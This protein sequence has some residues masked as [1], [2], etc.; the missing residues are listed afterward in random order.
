MARYT[1]RLLKSYF[2]DPSG[3]ETDD[4]VKYFAQPHINDDEVDLV[5][6]VIRSKGFV[7]GKY[8][9][10]LEAE[11]AE[12]VG[13]K[14]AIVTSNGTAALHLAI[15][16]LGITPGSE[17]ITPAF[18]FIASANAI[19]FG[20]SVPVFADIDPRTYNIDPD[21][22]RSLIT[23][24]T[25]AILPVHIFG[26][27]ADMIALSELAEDHSLYI[28]EDACQGHG[29]YIDNKHVGS[30]GNVGCFSFYATKNLTSGEGG[31]IVTDDDELAA[32]IRSLKNHGRDEKGGYNH[33][34]I[35]Y[36][37]RLADPLA[38]L[39]LV[40]LR[41]LPSMLEKR[42]RN[43]RAI[44]RV[45]DEIDMVRNQEIPNSFTHS[46]YI[47]AP[48]IINGELSAPN[49][50]SKL[51]DE[52]IGSRQIYTLP[53]HRQQTYLEGI[54]QWRWSQYVSYPDYAK[55]QLPHTDQ[56]ARSHFEIPIHPGVTESEIQTMG[57]LLLDLFK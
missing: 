42:H 38:A 24:K 28:I 39:G 8:A 14:H 19:S 50:V 36:N 1:A 31:M 6:Q 41:K 16:G 35:G 55:V 46:D 37:F 4:I 17:V 13:V 22:V 7:E 23:P 57:A 47:C 44:R 12:F 20:G 18:T 51:Q 25:Q 33:H 15:E 45:I 10:S 52:G 2:P 43:A 48:N 26:L 30:F 54:K 34:L 27:S 3:T 32:R 29:A 5:G 40:Q 11:F 9:R 56:I 21:Q 53:C 49:V